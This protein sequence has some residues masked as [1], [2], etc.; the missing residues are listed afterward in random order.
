[1][2][3]RNR[4]SYLRNYY[5]IWIV[6]ITLM[7]T[8]LHYSTI[9]KLQSLHDIYRALYYVPVLFAAIFFGLKGATLTYLFVLIV[10]LPFIYSSWTGVFIFETDRLLHL[11]LQG[12]F[13]VFAG[14]FVDRDRKQREE[15]E[16]ERYLAGVGQ[17]ATTIVHDLKNPLITIRGFSRRILEGK[18]N[19]NTAAQ[20]IA[21]SALQMEKIVYDV[22]DFA[23]PVKLELR[24][25]DMRNVINRACDSCKTK[26]E[27]QGVDL[28][29]NL[30]ADPVN[31]TADAFHI[32]RAVVNL[33]NN[34]IEASRKGQNISVSMAPGEKYLVIRF[35]DE[36]SGMDKDT[37]DNLFMPFYTSKSG[38]TGLGM[39]ISKKI[40]EAHKGTIDIYSQPGKGTEVT[41]RLPYG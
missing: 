4:M 24:Q 12:I 14:Y 18:G 33:I 21:D 40:I 8:Y 37:L 16:K 3:N 5:A 6:V 28:S 26:A 34:A 15:L 41:I 35:K 19:V 22:L 39:P 7:I 1:M 30:P 9:P 36:G 32:E 11:F 31:V 17:V 38:G 13:G 23:K 2:E 20:E 29:L 10:Y 27:D 25:E